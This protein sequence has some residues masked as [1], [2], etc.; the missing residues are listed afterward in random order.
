MRMTHHRSSPKQSLYP[1]LPR[2]FLATV[3]F[4][5]R[6]SIADASSYL[7]PASGQPLWRR[8]P[9]G[10][11]KE[12][13]ARATLLDYTQT[14]QEGLGFS[15]AAPQSDGFLWRALETAIA[16]MEEAVDFGRIR[17]QS[18]TVVEARS[19]LGGASSGTA[20]LL[21]GGGAVSE[22]EIRSALDALSPRGTEE[23]LVPGPDVKRSEAGLPTQRLYSKLCAWRAEL[24][25]FGRAKNSTMGTTASPEQPFY[26]WS[27]GQWRVCQE[28][29]PLLDSWFADAVT[30]A[31]SSSPTPAGRRSSDHARLR[32]AQRAH[33]RAS[34]F[35]RVHVAVLHFLG[36]TQCCTRTIH[37]QLSQFLDSTRWSRA[38][39]PAFRLLF[40]CLERIFWA[41]SFAKSPSS[42]RGAL[43]EDAIGTNDLARY[44][45]YEP[46]T[47]QMGMMPLC[48]HKSVLAQGGVLLDAR[49][50]ACAHYE[51]CQ[52][53]HLAMA[54][55]K[56]TFLDEQ[57]R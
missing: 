51:F 48:V 32:L 23:R 13:V 45:V 28:L 20:L 56:F 37:R 26:S 5:L 39:L 24:R 17:C 6:E 3:L 54:I 8:H 50:K 34:R 18:R 7:D 10:S 2:N 31:S 40:R 44:Y 46:L 9:P 21:A 52:Q 15:A 25:V 16:A 19:S 57:E 55:D 33:A 22:V 53:A 36:R 14:L 38:P 30:E 47:I 12:A 35:F 43:W 27:G 29:P 4:L 42:L 1:F 41:P 11:H 49:T